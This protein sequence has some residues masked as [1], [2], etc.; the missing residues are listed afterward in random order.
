MVDAAEPPGSGHL[1]IIEPW[2][3]DG[4]NE[5]EVRAIG[6]NDGYEP[7]WIFEASEPLGW[8]GVMTTRLLLAPRGGLTDSWADIVD[9][10]LVLNGCLHTADPD[11]TYCGLVAENTPHSS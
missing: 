4:Q 5:R 9:G 7:T 2:V 10:K 8:N 11:A 3:P 6:P 1:V